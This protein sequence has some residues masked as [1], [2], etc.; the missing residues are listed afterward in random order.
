MFRSRGAAAAVG[1]LASLALASTGTGTA[2]FQPQPP[3]RRNAAP[4][5]AVRGHPG[6]SPEGSVVDAP[7]GFIDG[8]LRGAAMRLHTRK[9]APKEGRAAEKNDAAHGMGRMPTT[10]ADYAQ[11]LVD[12]REVYGAFEEAV[13]GLDELE[14]LRSTGLERTE[15]LEADLTF[16]VE[17]KGLNAVPELGGAGRAY[18]A[19]VRRLAADGA[20]PELVCHYYN[21]YFAHSAGGRMIGKQMSALLLDRHTLNFHQWPKDGADGGELTDQKPQH[22]LDPVRDEI[23][24][25]AAA[26]SEEERQRCV[27]ETA[28]TFKYGGS[29]NSILMGGSS[30]H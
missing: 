3:R 6:D 26:W 17:E 13:A 24:R 19:E 5:V 12:S 15:A 28:A 21:H 9:Q 27:G 7:A 20:V 4:A 22:L 30:P 2:A 11:F 14:A 1:L 16:L 29:L 25:M 10:L 23:E 8:E 18:A